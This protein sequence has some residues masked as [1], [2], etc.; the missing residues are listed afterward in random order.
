MPH[1]IRQPELPQLPSDGLWR[2]ESEEYSAAGL[3]SEKEL[4]EWRGKMLFP[5]YK[6]ATLGAVA[7][8]NCLAVGECAATGADN[9]PVYNL[10]KLS[11][12]ILNP[13]GMWA[14]FR[15]WLREWGDVMALFCILIFIGTTA[16]NLTTII[17]A[18]VKAGLEAAADVG[19]RI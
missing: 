12:G 2:A 14:K 6:K 13:L 3:Y 10:A 15:T 8:G 4:D 19:R 18:A 5:S 1:L 7:Y 9:I 16:G 17:V 11:P